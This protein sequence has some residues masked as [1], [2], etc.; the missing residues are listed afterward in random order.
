MDPAGADAYGITSLHKFASWNKTVY[1]D[2]L[3]PK[4][5]ATQ[6]NATCPANKTALH[7][8]VEMAAVGAVKTLVAAGADA[9]AKDGNG[10]TVSAAFFISCS[11]SPS[12]S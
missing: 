8:A 6:L 7:W 11:L 1:L 5:T 2:M 4:L 3:L 12:S 10:R 9:D